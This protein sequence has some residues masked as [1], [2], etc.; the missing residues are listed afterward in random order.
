MIQTGTFDAAASPA[1]G[2]LRDRLLWME[3]VQTA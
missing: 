3:A 2:A 1:K